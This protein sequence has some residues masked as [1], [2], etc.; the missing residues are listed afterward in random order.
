[1]TRIAIIGGGPGGLLTAYLLEQK[2]SAHSQITLFEASDRI[3]GKIVSEQFAAAPVPYEAGVAE[4]YDYSMIGPDPLRQLI[5]KLRLTTV[6]M[7]GKTVVM[8]DRILR[9]PGHI[10][11][12]L[13]EKTLT[14]I[15]EFRERAS[16][17]LSPAN[18]YEAHWQDDNKHPWARRSCDSI[19]TE[20]TDAAALRYLKV[21]A[22]SD[23][24]TEPHLTNGLNGLKNFLM[25]VPGYIRLYSI[26]GGI[27]LLPQALRERISA[28]V[29][30]NCSVTRIEKTS[31]QTYRVHYRRQG[32]IEAQDFDLVVVALPNNWLPAI[33]WGGKRLSAAM[34]KHHAYYDNPG[35][36]LRIS[37]LFQQPF[38]RNVIN[39]S[40]FMLDAFG[41]CCVYDETARQNGGAYGALSWLLAGSDAVT[42]SNFAEAALIEKALESLPSSFAAGRE[43]F[44]EGRVHRWLGTV[45]GLPGGY[46]TKAPE[47]RHLPEPKE[48]PGLFVVGDYLFDSTINGVLD[49]ADVVTDL[50]LSRLM[51]QRYHPFIADT[52]TVSNNGK[53]GHKLGNGQVNRD[54]RAII[55][56]CDNTESGNLKKA[57]HDFYDGERGYEES[58]E[59]YF[60]AQYTADLIEIV[61]RAKPPYRLLDSGSASGQTLTDFAEIGIDA[62]GIE[63]SE[64]IHRQTS[65]LWKHR[66]LL[67]DVRELPF[68]DSYFDFVYDT[69]L[70]YLPENDVDQAIR[71]LHRVAKCGVFFGGITTDMTRE[72]IE[73]HDLFYGVKTLGTLW[74]WSERFL[75]NGFRLAV[76][77]ARTLARAWKCETEANEGDDPWYPN[78]ESMRYC[79]YTKQQNSVRNEIKS[80]RVK[81][82]N[83][84]RVQ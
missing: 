19:L 47:M 30:L 68:E 74:E 67:G 56:G 69:C 43:M 54:Q 50:M 75:R 44:I 23:L 4:L 55:A 28:H 41:G 72:V 65:P 18:Y 76:M 80:S 38:W 84:R 32:Q 42:M 39:E 1:M 78:R 14:A 12:H 5:R 40:Y 61:W 48:H 58:Y 7:S 9:T 64:H 52:F 59:E 34:Q 82:N 13:G 15:T 33:E 20:V 70:C 22:H 26:A 16:A 2:N 66:N 49:S 62:W 21:A 36:Y 8:D 11:R 45:N 6:K 77:D 17:L 71:E 10:K 81:V 63:N 60:D 35:H 46:P 83:G 27:E 51:K 29:K 53:N 25:D 37:I 24:A 3:G 73:K 31:D 79:F 57:Y